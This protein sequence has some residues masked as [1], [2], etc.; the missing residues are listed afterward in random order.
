LG[1]LLVGAFGWRAAFLVNLPVAG[2]A[3]LLAVRGMPTDSGQPPIR[4]LKELANRIDL[5]GVVGFATTLSALMVFLMGLPHANWIALTA[6]LTL[7][8]LL[9]RWELRAAIPFFD[10]RQLRGNPALTRTYSRS[11]LTLMGSYTV[12][13]GATQWLEAGPGFSA[14]QAGLV[15]LP[16]GACSALL[17]RPLARRNLMRGPLIASGLALIAGSV[18]LMGLTSRNPAPLLVFV[19]LMFGVANATTTVGNQIALFLQAPRDSIGAAAGLF[20]TFGY[21]GSII[22]AFITGMVFKH[23]VSDAGMHTLGQLLAVVGLVV[24]AMSVLDRQ[25]TA[26]SRH[27]QATLT[28]QEVLSAEALDQT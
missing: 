15:L 2:L 23:G 17:C 16:M 8:P 26:K 11:A 22:S 20:R 14:A 25:L 24:L 27:M 3:L 21:L 18:G 5:P 1:G 13:Y 12:M 9:V 19:T 10:V 4:G 28:E 7:A 6:A